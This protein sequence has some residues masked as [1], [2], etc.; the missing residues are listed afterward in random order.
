MF[1]Q[2]ITARV[3]DAAAVREAFDRWRTDVMPSAIGFLG[4]TVGVTKDGEL[5]VVAR[6]SSEADARKNSALEEQSAWWR[7]IESNLDAPTFLDCPEADVWGDGGSDQAGFVQVITG[8]AS[9]V[10]RM[11]RLDEQMDAMD[12]PDVIGGTAAWSGDRFVQTVYFTNEAEARENEAKPLS[13]SD[14][15]MMDEFR[16]LAQDLRFYDLTEPVM[17]TP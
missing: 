10:E 15:A 1:I 5:V 7:T 3:K 13:E 16:S 11:K 9:D 4:S 12:R 14:Q 2:F 8:R 6:F 17:I